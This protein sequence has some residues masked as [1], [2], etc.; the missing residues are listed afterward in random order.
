MIRLARSE[1]G[2]VVGGTT[3]GM[4]VAVGFG[5]TVLDGSMVAEMTTVD[6][7]RLSPPPPHAA[8][9]TARTGV[10]ITSR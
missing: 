5:G 10:A 8:A 6:S 9:I 7:T 1:D 2:S 4:T 3:V